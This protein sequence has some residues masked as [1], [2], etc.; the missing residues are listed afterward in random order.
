MLSSE[1]DEVTTTCRL[2][3]VE[4]KFDLKP[5]VLYVGSWYWHFGQEHT[6]CLDTMRTGLCD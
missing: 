4:V 5:Q 3:I 6:S 2:G 1:V